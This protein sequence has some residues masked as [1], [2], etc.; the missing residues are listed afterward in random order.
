MTGERWVLQAYHAHGKFYT[1][2]RGMSTSVIT[3]GILPAVRY[4]LEGRVEMQH[5]WSLD[6]SAPFLAI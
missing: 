2:L 5:L 1:R 6:S 4:R 3:S